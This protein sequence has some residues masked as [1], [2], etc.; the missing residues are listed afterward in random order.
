MSLSDYKSVYVYGLYSDL[1]RQFIVHGHEVFVLSP[2]ERRKKEKE[3]V[4]HENGA[5]I[6]KLKIWN[7]QKTNKFEKTV[8]M[9]TIDNVF[10]KGI[11]KYFSDVTFD[12][13]LFPT[14]PITLL[15]SANYVKRRDGANVYLLLKDIFPQNSVDIGMLSTTGLKGALYKYFRSKEKKLY[16]ISDKIGCMSKANVDYVI[17]HNPDVNPDKLEICPNSIEV[18]D[19]S[20]TE[21][22]RNEMRNKYSLPLDKKIYVYGG[23]LGKPQGIE[24]MINCLRSQKEN[25]NIFFLIVGA[26]TEYGK[27]EKFVI[28]EKQKN[29]KLMKHMPREDYDRMIAACDIGMIFLDYRFTIPNFPSRLLAYMQAKLPVLAVTDTNS[30]IGEAILDGNF[31]WWCKSN[32]ISGFCNC[33]SVIERTLDKEW[34]DMQEKE[35][36][37]LKKNYSVENS[38]KTIMN[39]LDIV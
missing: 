18:R 11:K 19:M 15:N 2:I 30:D 14:P 17:K 28:E 33:V 1:L 36:E 7:M 6:V 5:T 32:D 26:G 37:Y 29:V 27:I 39:R 9:L 34:F 35:Y 25:A 22:E 12:L 13:V 23:N 38:Y 10:I 21:N 24:Y 4:I 8:S 31:G 20:L 3:C 16:A